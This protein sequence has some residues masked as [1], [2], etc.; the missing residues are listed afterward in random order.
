MDMLKKKRGAKNPSF[1]S[2]TFF[3]QKKKNN[4]FSKLLK[5]QF[6]SLILCEP[7]RR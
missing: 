6:Q 3:N 4:Q 5:S 2:R 7:D 1:F